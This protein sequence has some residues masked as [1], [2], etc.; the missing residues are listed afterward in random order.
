MDSEDIETWLSDQIQDLINSPGY[1]EDPSD[2]RREADAL[3]ANAER[4]GVSHSDLI[5]FCNGDIERYLLDK[6]NAFT[7]AEVRRK[8]AKDD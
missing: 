7:D 2:M 8:V 1:H 6:Q 4:D 3:R 5:D